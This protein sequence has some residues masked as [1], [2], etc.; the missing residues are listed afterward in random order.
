MAGY[1]KISSHHENRGDHAVEGKGGVMVSIYFG[2]NYFNAQPR[3]PYWGY[4]LLLTQLIDVLEKNRLGG[5]LEILLRPT[6]VYKR[7]TT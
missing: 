5:L 3:S 1:C 7:H 4:H 6:C 2:F